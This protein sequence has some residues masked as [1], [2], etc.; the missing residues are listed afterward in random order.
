MLPVRFYYN[1]I[2]RGLLRSSVMFSPELLQKYLKNLFSEKWKVDG[3]TLHNKRSAD[4]SPWHTQINR[5][6]N[7]FVN[8][9]VFPHRPRPARPSS[10]CSQAYVSSSETRSSTR[11]LWRFRPPRSSLVRPSPST[12]LLSPFV[13]IFL[14]NF[15]EREEYFTKSTL[16]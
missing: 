6:H 1:I 10:G 2:K 13:H 16:A 12:L 14:H 9:Y 4:I 3:S 7:M 11:A 15:G 5:L 8:P